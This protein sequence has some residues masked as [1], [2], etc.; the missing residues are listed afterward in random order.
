MRLF[1]SRSPNC[2]PQDGTF[3]GDSVLKGR[4]K[5]RELAGSGAVHRDGGDIRRGEDTAE[6]GRGPWG[7]RGDDD[8][9]TPRRGPWGPP[10][11]PG[12]LHNC[13]HTTFY[14][15]M[16]LGLRHKQRT[17]S[18]WNV[19]LKSQQQPQT[20]GVHFPRSRA[21]WRQFTCQAGAT[22]A[23]H[24]WPGPHLSVCGQD[25]PCS[26]RVGPVGTQVLRRTGRGRPPPGTGTARVTLHIACHLEQPPPS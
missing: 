21:W 7:T 16:P 10:P 13:E 20:L 11:A 12:H 22:V 1:L 15:F 25:H 17:V 23:G 6:P 4:V 8:S 2:Q 24:G 18:F 19:H 3:F 26:A 5:C 9:L 14:Y